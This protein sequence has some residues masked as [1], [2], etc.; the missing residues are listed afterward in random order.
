MTAATEWIQTNF[1][2]E[3]LGII[4][5][6]AYEKLEILAAHDHFSLED[7]Q[8]FINV[9]DS[10]ITV[11][12]VDTRVINKLKYIPKLKKRPI[13]WMGFT[14]DTQEYI[15]LA[16][17]WVM[18]NFD[19]PYL[20]QVVSACGSKKSFLKVPP[21]RKR[22]H[23]VLQLGTAPVIAYPQKEG[24]RTCMI[25]AMTSALHFFG[26]KD[27]AKKIHDR[28]KA[29][30]QAKNTFHYFVKNLNENF[31]LLR[32]RMT[33]PSKDTDILEGTVEG[34]YLVQLKGSDGKED[35]CVALTS[36]WIFDSNFAQAWPRTRDSLNVCCSTDDISSYYVGIVEIAC[37][38]GVKKI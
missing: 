13:K 18:A 9:E 29:Y 20:E 31:K 4:Q 26:L 15:T 33:R 32:K 21:G 22:K 28:K 10:Q 3:V 5:K 36:D 23:R 19:E 38:Q 25:Y 34:I 17:V 35:H 27:I 12:E 1:K 6:V 11:S 8:G 14:N 7:R 24:E 2:K 37:F 16:T 30:I